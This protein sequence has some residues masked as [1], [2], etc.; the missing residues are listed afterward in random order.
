MSNQ[1]HGPAALDVLKSFLDE[2]NLLLVSC[3]SLSDWQLVPLTFSDSA[4]NALVG[5]SN[6][7]IS[8]RR[9]SARA[10]ATRCF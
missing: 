4:S 6:S 1:N 7:S 10:I 8:G 2:L 9:I 3:S 5:S